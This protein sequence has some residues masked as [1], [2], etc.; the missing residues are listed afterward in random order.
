MRNKVITVQLKKE[1]K[2]L[3]TYLFHQSIFSSLSLSSSS[4]S[5]IGN[6]NIAATPVNCSNS[7]KE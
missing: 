7:V 4:S 2:S 1:N 3:L 6:R 5:G